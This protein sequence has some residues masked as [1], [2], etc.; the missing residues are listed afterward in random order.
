LSDVGTAAVARGSRVNRDDFVCHVGTLLVA[1]RVLKSYSNR[2][3]LIKFMGRCLGWVMGMGGD[4][5]WYPSMRNPLY[6]SPIPDN[7]PMNL[8]H[9][10]IP[11]QHTE[12]TKG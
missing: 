2:A 6:P 8:P 5:F 4:D 10:R 11:K 9:P 3:N 12:E 7:T 1:G